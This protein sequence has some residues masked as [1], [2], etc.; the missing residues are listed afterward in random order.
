[1]D[2][3]SD[4]RG[5]AIITPTGGEYD[6]ALFKRDHTFS[7]IS[8][9]SVRWTENPPKNQRDKGDGKAWHQEPNKNLYN[10]YDAKMKLLHRMSRPFNSVPAITKGG[11]I[12]SY[13]DRDW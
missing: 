13:L 3:T 10:L 8:N 9:E 1:M 2:L 7:A 11:K 4:Q 12:D 5:V 6:Q